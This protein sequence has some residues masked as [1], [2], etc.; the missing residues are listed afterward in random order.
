MSNPTRINAL[1][2]A[3]MLSAAA[4]ALEDSKNHA[5][6]TYGDGVEA[7]FADLNAKA[8]GLQDGTITLEAPAL[9]AQLAELDEAQLAEVLAAY[10]SETTRDDVTIY[11]NE[12]DE[13]ERDALLSPYMPEVITSDLQPGGVP[14]GAALPA[15]ATPP[16]FFGIGEGLF[17]TSE[18]DAVDYAH[19]HGGAGD[20][21]PVPFGF[22]PPG[23]AGDYYAVGTAV[24][25]SLEAAQRNIYDRGLNDIARP[26]VNLN[27]P[28]PGEVVDEELQLS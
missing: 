19:K 23:V 10:P 11:L 21:R 3:T 15:E 18:A 13:D 24:F 16:A 17:F 5:K 6:N 26:L 28:V 12:M 22:A 1:A 25:P 7:L 20:F 4:S 2:I 27:R 9:E 14:Q 8:V